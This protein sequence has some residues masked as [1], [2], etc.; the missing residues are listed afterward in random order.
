MKSNAE[1]HESA[2]R[3]V[4]GLIMKLWPLSS[5]LRFTKSGHP[6][7][8]QLRKVPTACTA[9]RTP[10]DTKAS[11]RR[12]LICVSE[13]DCDQSREDTAPYPCGGA[14]QAPVLLHRKSLQRA[15]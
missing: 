6:V 9:A 4:L 13:C 1:M 7:E 2:P 8:D 5:G 3:Y 15:L 14:R 12:I 10:H 11:A